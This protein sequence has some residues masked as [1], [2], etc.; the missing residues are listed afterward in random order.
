MD[1]LLCDSAASLGCMLKLL[2]L[3]PFLQCVGWLSST[4]AVPCQAQ[5]FGLESDGVMALE[6]SSVAAA[7]RKAGCRE[8]VDCSSGS[9]ISE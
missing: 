3:S 2:L 9:S 6:R 7:L 8:D 5:C 4:V 1:W